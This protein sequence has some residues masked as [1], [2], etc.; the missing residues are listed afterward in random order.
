VIGIRKYPLLLVLAGI[1]LF[2]LA[3]VSAETQLG[4]STIV[5]DDFCGAT[6]PAEIVCPKTRA[7]QCLCALEPQTNSVESEVILPL[8]EATRKPAPKRKRTSYRL[9]E[10][11]SWSLSLLTFED[12]VATPPPRF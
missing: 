1:M 2:F 12:S 11:F 5:A 3:P 10:P 8:S 7:A 4:T 6:P 9:L